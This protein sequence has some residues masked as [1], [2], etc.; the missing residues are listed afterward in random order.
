LRNLRTFAI[1]SVA[2]FVIASIRGI[3]DLTFRLLALCHCANAI[4]VI[5]DTGSSSLH[6]FDFDSSGKP[7]LSFNENLV[8]QRVSFISQKGLDEVEVD[9]F[10]SIM[11]IALCFQNLINLELGFRTASVGVCSLSERL[12]A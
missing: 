7:G 11:Q 9:A 3:I 12:V 10:S 2:S 5:N 8:S 6:S 1:A 4:I